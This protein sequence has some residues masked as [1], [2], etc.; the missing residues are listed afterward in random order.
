L[1]LAVGEGVEHRLDLRAGDAE[2]VRDALRFER[3]DNRL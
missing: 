1:D 3:P 2:D